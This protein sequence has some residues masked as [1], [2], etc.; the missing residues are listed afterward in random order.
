M[1]KGNVSLFFVPLFFL[2]IRR[3]I[4]CLFIISSLEAPDPNLYCNFGAISPL[5]TRL[6]AP[7]R[8]MHSPSWKTGAK[9][10]PSSLPFKSCIC[11]FQCSNP[12]LLRWFVMWLSDWSRPCNRPYDSRVSCKVLGSWEKGRK[13]GYEVSD[14]TV[15]SQ[16]GCDDHP[17]KT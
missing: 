9:G 15:Q 7:Q 2:A 12:G 6:K 11:L 1:G 13:V 3:S 16:T 17:D 8:H 4:I 10:R 5:S 14:R